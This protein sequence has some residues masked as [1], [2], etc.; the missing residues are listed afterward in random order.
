MFVFKLVSKGETTKE[1]LTIA[2]VI[3]LHITK[4]SYQITL[5]LAVKLHHRFGSNEIVALL[6]SY[7]ILVTYDEVLRFRVFVAKYFGEK[8]YISRELRMN[9]AQK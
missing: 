3:Q 2:Q 9:S 6:H 1:S 8:Q 4:S 7:G 5:G